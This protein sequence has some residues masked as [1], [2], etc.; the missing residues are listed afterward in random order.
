[1]IYDHDEA[2]KEDAHTILRIVWILD[3]GG[4]GNK[5]C[6]YIHCNIVDEI[7]VDELF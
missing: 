4:I 5:V 7:M 6:L 3:Y 1:M 2:A